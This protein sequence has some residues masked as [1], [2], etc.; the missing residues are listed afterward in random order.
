MPTKREEKPKFHGGSSGQNPR[1]KPAKASSTTAR[2]EQ[3]NPSTTQLMEAV[4]ERSNRI[5]ALRQVERNRGSAGVDETTVGELG[6]YLKE[7]WPKIKEKLVEGSYQPVAVRRIEIAKPSGGMRQ[8]GI[9]TVVDRLVQ[10]A[11]HQVLNRSWTQTF[12]SRATAF[13]LDAERPSGSAKSA[14][15]CR[16]RQAMAGGYRLGEVL[17]S[18]QPRHRDVS[19]SETNQRQAGADIDSAL[20][21]SGHH[22]GRTDHSESRGHSARR[23]ALAAIIQHYTRRSRQRVRASG[24]LVLPLRG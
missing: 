12:R 8:L 4:V 6:E 14:G 22:G 9:P 2:E 13:V 23:T 3:T 17:R 5:K 21:S 15:L 16:Q 18:G 20:P 10:Q 19:G 1:G 7:H 24:A 11:I